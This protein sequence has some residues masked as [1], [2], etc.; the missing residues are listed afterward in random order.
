MENSS[1]GSYNGQKIDT[2]VS[3]IDFPNVIKNAGLNGF[4]DSK[5]TKEN[6]NVQIVYIV[7]KGDTLSAIAQ[8]YHTTVDS[9]VKK[10]KIKNPDLIYPNQQIKI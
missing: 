8:K 9:L 4:S 6:S 5:T 3:F 1:S 2:D 7:K 10:N